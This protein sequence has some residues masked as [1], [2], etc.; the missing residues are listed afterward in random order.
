MRIWLPKLL[1]VTEEWYLSSRDSLILKTF[2]NF[3][4]SGSTYHFHIHYR[5]TEDLSESLR[6]S[7]TLSNYMPDSAFKGPPLLIQVSC[8]HTGCLTECWKETPVSTQRWKVLSPRWPHC[9]LIITLCCT[10]WSQSILCR[11]QL[12]Q[13]YCRTMT[14]PFD[15]LRK[16][17][18][19]MHIHQILR[20]T[21]GCSELVLTQSSVHLACLSRSK[22]TLLS[23]W[24]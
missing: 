24:K 7:M 9:F 1:R 20:C 11:C 4:F 14:W 8:Q 12:K 23:D 5:K 16:Q 18:Y 2:W 15:C 10:V 13:G 6:Y 22:G 19:I 17:E 21:W 3:M